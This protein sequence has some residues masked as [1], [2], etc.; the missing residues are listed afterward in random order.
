MGAYG[1][2][3]A[4]PASLTIVEKP[5]KMSFV[6]A[7]AVPLGGLNALHFMRLARIGAGTTVLINGAGG[8]IGAHAVQ[9][10]RAMGAEVTG[11]D[12]GIK[13]DFVRRLGADHFIDYTQERFTA[14]GR[15]YDVLFDMV[16][17]GSYAARI[18]AIVLD[19]DAEPSRATRRGEER[20]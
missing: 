10:A 15:R 8:S 19:L 14:S 13:A 16:P 11:V 2:H 18:G 4:L 9:I 7:A 1:E 12:S 5:S 6:E 3:V 20:R 17:H